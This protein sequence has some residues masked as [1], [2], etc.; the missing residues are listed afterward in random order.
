MAM[1]Q[2]R[3]VS[4]VSCAPAPPGRRRDPTAAVASTLIAQASA[5]DAVAFAQLYDLTAARVYG[6]ALRIVRN[7]AEAEEVAQ[8]SFIEVWRLSG[9]FDPQR[10]SAISWILMLTHSAAVN[11]V[12]SEQASLQREATYQGQAQPLALTGSDTTFDVAHAS[13][14]ARRVHDALAELPAVQLEA[15]ELAYF[16]LL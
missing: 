6:L 4:D 16:G 14:E 1:T 12:R 2:R 15:L 8:E 10:G 11:R 3:D 9:R 7:S 13:L 5:G